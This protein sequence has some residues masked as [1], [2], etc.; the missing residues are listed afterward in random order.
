MTYLS[1]QNMNELKEELLLTET[2]LWSKVAKI[3]E[4]LTKSKLF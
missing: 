3:F 2:L 4:L 1:V